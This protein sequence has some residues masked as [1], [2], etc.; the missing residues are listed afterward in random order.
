MNLDRTEDANDQHPGYAGQVKKEPTTKKNAD[1]SIAF[2]EDQ[3]IVFDVTHVLTALAKP[4]DRASFTV[5]LESDGAEFSW[6]GVELA[7]IQK[8]VSA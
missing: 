5:F 8:E 4:G 2:K 7:I 3:I 1:G 6:R